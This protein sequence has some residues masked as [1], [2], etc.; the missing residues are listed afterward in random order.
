M[1]K[2]RAERKLISNKCSTE[3][4]L[5]WSGPVVRSTCQVLLAGE[6][7]TLPLGCVVL[8]QGVWWKA[9]GG[10]VKGPIELQPR[11]GQR[12]TV[13]TL[14]MWHAPTEAPHSPLRTL[15]TAPSQGISLLLIQASWLTTCWPRAQTLQNNNKKKIV[16]SQWVSATAVDEPQ[17]KKLIFSVEVV[18]NL[19][20]RRLTQNISIKIQYFT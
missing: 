7:P 8:P 16:Y 20:S 14:E 17:F 12:A 1:Q 3:G 19:S 10:P 11:A 13:W 15:L 18:K 5:F 6:S 2:N 4:L 9:R